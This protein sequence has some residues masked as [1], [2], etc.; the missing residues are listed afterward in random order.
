MERE[1]ERR[2]LAAASAHLHLAAAAHYMA[3]AGDIEMGHGGHGGGLGH[4]GH[5]DALGHGGHGDDDDGLG[6]HDDEGTTG[7]WGLSSALWS[8][9]SSSS[10]FWFGDFNSSGIRTRLEH[11]MLVWCFESVV[12]GFQSVQIRAPLELFIICSSGVFNPWSGV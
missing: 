7:C 6:H 1:R 11:D 10:A 8:S 12:W 4:G 5:G 2:H 3:E 9:I